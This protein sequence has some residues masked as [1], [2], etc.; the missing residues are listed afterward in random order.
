MT[1]FLHTGQRENISK[2]EVLA[3]LESITVLICKLT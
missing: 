3:E 2:A 1:G